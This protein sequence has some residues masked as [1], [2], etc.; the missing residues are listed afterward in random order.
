MAGNSAAERVATDLRQRVLTGQLRP[1]ARLSQQRI[2]TEYGTSRMP[3][4]D[5]LLALARDRLVDVTAT[6]AVV[7]PLSAAELQE[8]YELREAVEPLLTWIAVPNLRRG[9]LARMAAVLQTMEAGAAP[10]EWLE[11]DNQFHGLIYSCADRP[12]IIEIT[13]HLRRLT[14]RYLHLHLG[15][16]EKMGQLHE[17]HRRIYSAVGHRN[18][19]AAA[20]LMRTHL[21]TAHEILR[22]VLARS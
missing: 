14:G 11:L 8:L 6:A 20:R 18:A 12:H 1:G 15:V 21:A 16:F 4:R 22:E 17:D 9:D 7:C 13:D 5:A 2:A 19:A 3:A 10:A